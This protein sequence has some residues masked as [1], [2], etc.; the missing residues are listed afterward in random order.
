[1]K[2]YN[3][4]R[5]ITLI[6]LVVSIIVLLILAGI[7]INMLTGE[8]GILNRASEA[9]EKTSISQK[10]ERLELSN[11]EE[12]INDNIN[13]ANVEKVTDDKPGS[14]E[15]ESDNVYIINSIEDLIFF[16]Y[17]VRNG[18]T[19]EGNTI[20]LGTSLDFNS[21]KS[22]CDFLRTD[23]ERYG[24]RGE[25][26]EE[27]ISGI[28]WIPIGDETNINQNNF[29][30]IFDGNNNSIYNL[31]ISENNLNETKYIGFFANNQGIIKNLS[32]KNAK[33]NISGNNEVYFFV[34]GISGNNEGTIINCSTDGNYQSAG[35]YAL[36]SGIAGRNQG[37]IELCTNNAEISGEAMYMSGIAAQNLSVIK[38]CSNK[39]QITSTKSG[40]F[41]GGIS[42]LGNLANSSIED[43]FNTGDIFVTL[44]DNAHVGGIMGQAQCETKNC[45][46]T[47]N[48]FANIKTLNIRCNIGGIAG[49]Q[50]SQI[51]NCYNNG[52][53]KTEGLESELSIGGIIGRFSVNSIKNVYS[54][55]LIQLNNSANKGSLIGLIVDDANILEAK[56]LF[57][58][59]EEN[60]IGSNLSTK[61]ISYDKLE[62]KPNQLKILEIINAESENKFVQDTKNINNGY[63]IL[64]WQ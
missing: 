19:Y 1:M 11:M 23:Y 37:V 22:Y 46:N 34:S 5:G 24:Y 2:K 9:K 28:G 13:G 53:I 27:L 63:P 49:L 3:E 51:K 38:K 17:D 57:F 15:T 10:Q 43:S 16:S 62:E 41:L 29:K 32:L 59:G 47:G 30:G 45:Y 55:T 35:N 33:I 31:Y 58:Y 42:G 50:V 64:Y 8:N 21:T 25:L 39:G 40:R 12:I 7:S 18:N 36:I 61:E 14:L 44:Y 54:E 20:K 48:I 60:A 6:T 26:G 56:N 4:N 52:K